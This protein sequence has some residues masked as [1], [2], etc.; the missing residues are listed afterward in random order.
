MVAG[1]HGGM[2]TERI[3]PHLT[4]SPSRNICATTKFLLLKAMN[5]FIKDC[6]SQQWW[7][8]KFPEVSFPGQE[9]TH[10]KGLFRIHL[11]KWEACNSACFYAS[12][13]HISRIHCFHLVTCLKSECVLQFRPITITALSQWA[14]GTRLTLPETTGAT[15]QPEN[16][17]ETIS[18]RASSMDYHLKTFWNLFKKLETLNLTDWVS[19][20]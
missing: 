16:Y 17:F 7:K 1:R 12:K 8:R 6:H 10:Y 5:I 18:E 13:C 2:L 4:N 3:L 9:Y 20:A 11:V 14:A 15:P 19:V